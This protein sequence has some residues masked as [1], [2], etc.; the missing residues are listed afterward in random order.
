MMNTG[1]IVIQIVLALML[2]AI[3]TYTHAQLAETLPVSKGAYRFPYASGTTV[4]V[5]QD[6]VNHG[7]DI[8]A[9]GALGPRN[10]LDLVASFDN[11][12]IVASADGWI[13]YLDDSGF[14]TCP[15]SCVGYDGPAGASNCCPRGNTSCN[16]ACRN[17]YI[18]MRHANGEWTKYSHMQ[19]DSIPATLSKGQFVTAGT[20]LGF[21]GDIGFANGSHLHYEIG[22][23][24]DLDFSLPPEDPDYD[25]LG[26]DGDSSQPGVQC[27]VC[28][29]PFD[30]EVTDP[31]YSRRNRIPVFCSL[32]IVD[33]GDVITAGACD[34]LCAGSDNLVLDNRTV[35]DDEAEYFQRTNNIDIFDM[36]VEAGGGSSIRAQNRVRLMPG[37][38]AEPDSYFSA[39]IG[40]C[41]SPGT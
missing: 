24:L 20:F 2:L 30:G 14:L 36:V 33:A 18:W 8:P 1:K 41:D 38:S 29:L 37:F 6:H 19:T 25:P 15:N 5:S 34:G 35:P 22:F 16:G 11:A 40:A 28:G 39:S 21:E 26:I 31:S 4:T 10:R 23:P 32:G 12:S 9:N 17:N 7:N 27:T 13:E 3:T